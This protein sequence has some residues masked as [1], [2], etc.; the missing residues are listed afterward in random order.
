M[1]TAILEHRGSTARAAKKRHV[2]AQN[3]DASRPALD[4]I[5]RPIYRLPKAAQIT[6]AP[7]VGAD[8]LPRCAV[9]GHASK[10]TGKRT[11]SSVQDWRRGAGSKPGAPPRRWGRST[12][13]GGP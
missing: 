6:A 8:E 13:F 2:S 4:Q 3:L 12:S 7:G 10:R 9:F 1:R 5:A 11:D